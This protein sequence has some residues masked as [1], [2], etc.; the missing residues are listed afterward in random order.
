MFLQPQ[1]S[2]DGRVLGAEAL[3]RWQHP[4]RG[5]VYPGEFIDIFEKSGLIYRL[6][7][8]MWELAVKKLREWKGTE[9]EYLYLSV[10]IFCKGLLL[11]GYL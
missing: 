8:Y 5:L 4:V 10:N 3:V 1:V 6:D 11:H 2:T 7:K 9:K